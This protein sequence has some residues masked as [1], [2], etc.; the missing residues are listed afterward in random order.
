[1]HEYTLDSPRTTQNTAHGQTTKRP[2]SSAASENAREQTGQR[3]EDCEITGRNCEAEAMRKKEQQQ[4]HTHLARHQP[5]AS[6][7]QSAQQQR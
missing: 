6:W 4:Q 1:M 2:I 3:R 7:T 5:S